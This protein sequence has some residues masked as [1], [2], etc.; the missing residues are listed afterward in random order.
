[1][2]ISKL[3]AISSSFLKANWLRYSSLKTLTLATFSSPIIS[4]VAFSGL[5]CLNLKGSSS[6]R[7]SVF[8]I[9]KSI[10]FAIVLLPVPFAPYL[11]FNTFSL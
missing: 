5:F 11:M 7:S 3:F 1:M 8:V 4:G 9:F 6:E 10:A 2:K